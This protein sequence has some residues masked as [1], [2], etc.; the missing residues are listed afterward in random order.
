MK[1]YTQLSKLFK[2][3]LEWE[4]WCD[5]NKK[6]QLQL[7]VIAL[8]IRVNYSPNRDVQ[9]RRR[10]LYGEPPGGG[11]ELQVPRCQVYL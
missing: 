7:V 11:K 9:R 10:G 2:K 4:S 6:W 8:N 3:A 1:E 5:N